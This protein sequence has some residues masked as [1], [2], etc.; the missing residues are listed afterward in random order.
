M[1]DNPYIGPIVDLVDPYLTV[2]TKKAGGFKHKGGEYQDWWL[3]THPGRWALVGSHGM[4]LI[5]EWC[6]DR[7]YKYA[8]RN[9]HQRVYAQNPHPE[10]EPFHT[11]YKRMT[12]GNEM[13]I[14]ELTRDEFNWTPAELAEACQLARDNL[15]PVGSR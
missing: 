11:A 13:Y 4:G 2:D 9:P 3:R 10:G 1:S 14:P 8:T 6:L 12:Q 5:R 7:G 15:F